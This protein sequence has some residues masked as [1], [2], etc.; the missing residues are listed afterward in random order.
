MTE[1]AWVTV[2]RE[3]TEEMIAAG[4]FAVFENNQSAGT[5]VDDAL[6]VYRA[7]IAAAPVQGVDREEGS[8]CVIRA[9]T[10]DHSL[11]AS[12]AAPSAENDGQLFAD[13]Y[14]PLRSDLAFLWA[15][16]SY[17]AGG[18]ASGD[19]RAAWDRTIAALRNLS[20]VSADHLD[21]NATLRATLGRMVS[22]FGGA[23]PEDVEGNA[24]L[25]EA[26]R[27]LRTVETDQ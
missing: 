10:R 15:A 19:V 9:A 24:I 2:P 12:E 18:P 16:L 14:D 4:S 7:M 17:Y 8:S 3:P 21:E 22:Y 25:G 13:F 11:A 27:L 5:T 20:E 26:I 23:D 1:D 6:D